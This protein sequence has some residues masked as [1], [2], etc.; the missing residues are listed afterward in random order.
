MGEANL[1]E[2]ACFSSHFTVRVRLV[3]VVG[4]EQDASAAG[5]EPAREHTGGPGFSGGLGEHRLQP[6]AD[7]A[8]LGRATAEQREDGAES[9]TGAQEVRDGVHALREDVGAHTGLVVQEGAFIRVGGRRVHA[10]AEVD[11]DPLLAILAF[12]DGG[13]AV[14]AHARGVHQIV[15]GEDADRDRP[16]QGGDRLVERAAD[17]VVVGEQARSFTGPQ[18]EMRQRFGAILERTG[19]A[20]GCGNGHCHIITRASHDTQRIMMRCL[21][22]LLCFTAISLG[23]QTPPLQDSARVESTPPPPPPSPEQKRFLDGLRTATRGIAQLKDGLARVT[24]AGGRDTAAQRR[25][26]RLLSGLCGSGRAFMKR[27]RPQMSPTVYE[28]SVQ[29]KAKR[30]VTQVDSL[31]KYTTTCEDSATVAPGAT[32][33]GLGKRMKSYDAALRDF[34]VSIGLPV[35]EDTT[36][37][38]RRQ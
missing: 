34:R 38:T 1:L 5:R 29:F 22:V 18:E 3:C 37:T 36:K 21:A 6:T 2:L 11:K 9:E 4:Q 16:L 8:Q 32:V 30:L 24:R 31:I 35:K 33:L 27:G 28:D 15:G 25:A 10:G 26:G 23:A 12:H 7:V 19:L 17:R 14:G 20:R 13:G